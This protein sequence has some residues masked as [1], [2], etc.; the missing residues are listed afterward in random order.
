MIE[1]QL[2]AY[3]IA[4]QWPLT[5]VTLRATIRRFDTR[6]VRIVEANVGG[7]LG[8]AWPSPSPPLSSVA[9]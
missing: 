8:M 4:E 2:T 9:L 5:G 7:V 6:V 1:E 3:F